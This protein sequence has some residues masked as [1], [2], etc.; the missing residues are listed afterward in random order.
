MEHTQKFNKLFNVF[1]TQ[2]INELH[3]LID[4]AL[5]EQLEIQ[6][7]YGRLC[8][9]NLLI[10]FVIRNKLT[11]IVNSQLRNRLET[12]YSPLCVIYSREYG[13]PNLP[14]H[15]DR[16]DTDII[17]A[18]QLESSAITWELG[19]DANTYQLQ[20]NEALMF[21]PNLYVHW[22]PKLQFGPDDFVKMLFFRFR[23]PDGPSDYGHPDY[24]VDD[25]IFKEINDLRD[26]MY[27]NHS[28]DDEEFR[29]N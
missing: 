19:L 28:G 3:R 10:P 21:N 17:I 9:S 14:T 15:F 6:E 23:S 8:V 25:K 1:S 22:R 7:E 18:Y 16:D 20:D 24:K 5:P 27:A 29:E 26:E 12:S 2:E 11:E 4:N 13:E